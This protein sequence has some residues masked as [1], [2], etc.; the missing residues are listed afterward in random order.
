MPTTRRLP[1]YFLIDVSESTAGEVADRIDAGLNHF[2]TSL[3]RNPQALETAAVSIITFSGVAKQIVPLTDLVHFKR[4]RLTLGSGTALGSAIALWQDAM[5]REVIMAKPQSGHKSDYRPL[6][7][8]L[9]DG[10]PTDHWRESLS[11]MNAP[12]GIK[13]H[14]VAL[15]C[16]EHVDL[17]VLFALTPHVIHMK[18][19]NAS[20]FASFFRWVTQSVDMTSRSIQT[21]GTSTFEMPVLDPNYLRA[22]DR[23]LAQPIDLN[24]QKFMLVKC[25]TRNL[26]YILR[27]EKRLMRQ[28]GSTVTAY[29]AI[30]AHPVE[31]F[32]EASMGS[33]T[34]DNPI[35][36]PIA[37]P[38]CENTAI[39][40]CQCGKPHCLN[41]DAHKQAYVKCPHCGNVGEYGG[42]G[43]PVTS[44][45]GGAG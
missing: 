15:A 6:A 35:G 27:F 14:M 10:V 11:A 9:T 39:G 40:I 16:G 31:L 2:I 13:S 1:I 43:G 36:K 26:P 25:Q 5:K 38:H 34:I 20:A 21:S 7:F 23:S 30:A 22:A 45:R 17:E 12:D 24:H 29:E 33:A 28:N 41:S 32:D 19:A 8:L 3:R 37:C 42:D 44:L 18:E 4:P